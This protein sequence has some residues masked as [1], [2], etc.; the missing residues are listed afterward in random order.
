LEAT[1]S[2]CLFLN[3]ELLP[4]AIGEEVEARSHEVGSAIAEGTEGSG[5]DIASLCEVYQSASAERIRDAAEDALG[6]GIIETAEGP[7]P[8][9]TSIQS[10]GL[11]T[12]TAR[13]RIVRTQRE[14]FRVTGV[15]LLGEHSLTDGVRID[16]YAAKGVLLSVIDLGPGR[17]DLYS[18]HMYSGVLIT[19]PDEH[20]HVDHEDMLAVQTAQIEQ[21][22]RFIEQTH[23]ERNV[24]LLVGDFNMAACDNRYV[25]SPTPYKV[26]TETLG[27][28]GVGGMTMTDLWANRV[29][30]FAPEASGYTWTHDADSAA[31]CSLDGPYCDDS[32]AGPIPA[33]ECRHDLY[34]RIDYVF[35]ERPTDDHSFA[36]EFSR[37]RRR[38]FPRSGSNVVKPYL[39]DHLGLDFSLFASPLT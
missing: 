1:V 31:V 34:R 28:I 5:Y 24:A 26:L 8:S 33:R 32:A 39:S 4:E 29:L 23:D 7:G 19:G 11:M 16:A 2:R 21:I 18:T 37:P 13:R 38:S 3:T 30:A 15:S 12:V 35:V 17:I 22:A 25:G 9:L 14:A 36:L 27:N 20:T 10:S 6:S